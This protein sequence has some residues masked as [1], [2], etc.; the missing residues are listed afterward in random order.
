MRR[1]RQRLLWVGVSILGVLTVSPGSLGQ[2]SPASKPTVP[3]G[4]DWTNHHVIFSRPATTEQ[5]RRLQ[6]DPRYLQQLSRQSLAKPLADVA[7]VPVVQSPS[8]ASASRK[9]QRLKRDWSQDIGSG[10][11][12]T[13]GNYPAKYSF[14]LD[15]ANCSDAPQP[16]FV[17]YGTGLTGS[18]TQANIV[19]Y[20]NLYSGCIGTQ[21]AVYWA[22]NTGG[23]V[24]TSPVFSRDGTQVAFVMSDGPD[25][26]GIL[27]LL[28][29]AASTG[30]AVGAPITLFRTYNRLYPTC[31]A[32][33]F[34]QRVLRD[35]G[36]TPDQDTNSSVFYDYTDDIAYVGDDAG[37]LHK[38]TPV[39]NGI[40]NEIKTG[41]W[42]VQVNPTAA[43]ALSSP[44][45]DYGSGNVFVADKGGFLYR[46]NSSGT[47]VTSGQLDFSSGDTNGPGI[48]QGPVVDSTAGVVYLFASSDG[49][50]N[51][52]GGADCTAIYRLTTNFA[53]GT[54]GSEALVGVSTVEPTAPSPLYIGAFDSA[55]LGSSSAAGH[56]YV[57]GN[58][59]AA[60]TLYQIAIQNGVLGTVGAGPALSTVS[61]PCSPVT[62]VLNPNAPGGAT[63]WL[64]ASAQ[65][66]GASSG[67]STGG[68]I[69]NFKNTSWEPSA[70]YTVGQEILDSN[71]HIEVV[72]VGGTSGA[73]APFWTTGR[74]GTTTD[75][76][77]TWLNQGSLSAVTPGAWV[78]LTHYSKGAEILDSSNN[79]ELVTAAGT[80]GGTIPAFNAPPGGATTDG[81]V[82]WTNV[83]AIATNALPAAGGT[84]GIIY[85]NTVGSG[86]LPGASQVYFSTLSGGCGGTGNADGCAVQASQSALK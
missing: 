27:V 2:A 52:A 83:G 69:F 20:D 66:G 24:L 64:F 62:D 80:T 68:C 4:T 19:A 12:V 60:P 33:C 61:T 5:T 31:T 49:S 34:T 65:T 86:T 15:T 35:T 40:L 84:S 59:G 21:P 51:C 8:K 1:N 50:G 72:S 63:E 11:K 79:I 26:G 53:T 38:F 39:F 14:S 22:Y 85:D 13:A 74:A 18:G 54:S 46:V 43:T 78:A 55:Y 81:T 32:P 9:N 25:M 45:Y 73:T 3:V 70:M 56:L 77:V 82:T 57:C 41:G 67:C 17:V 7:S 58:T 37:Y 42:P 16:D 23:P 29:W 28:K 36:G 6:K 47:V 75:G 44:V 10:G 48:V 30:E 71:L 76:G